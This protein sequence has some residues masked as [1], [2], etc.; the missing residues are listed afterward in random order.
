MV[1]KEEIII[2]SKLAIYDKNNGENDK[3]IN[4]LYYRDYVYRKNFYARAFALLGCLIIIALYATNLL[5]DE[6]IDFFEID[7]NLLAISSIQIIGVVMVLYTLIGTKISTTEYR[8]I[9]QR[10]KA[11]F[12]LIR[13]L[14]KLKEKPDIDDNSYPDE[15][16]KLGSHSLEEEP[17]LQYGRITRSK[18]SDY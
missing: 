5:L 4:G 18:R 11:Y 15:L 17:T 13:D 6:Q 2:M 9:K 1:S 10:I 3:K 7:F 16:D 14:E 12:L 8:K